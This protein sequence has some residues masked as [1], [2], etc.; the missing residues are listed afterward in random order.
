[1]MGDIAP[2]SNG[3]FKALQ[4]NS[5]TGNPVAS[6]N[7]IN[8]IVA[9]PGA[10]SSGPSAV[11][12]GPQAKVY[13]AYAGDFYS[14]VVIGKNA[15]S[16]G[17]GSVVI[18]SGASLT[19]ASTQG[20]IIGPVCTSAASNPIAIGFNV[21]VSG[22]FAVAISNQSVTSTTNSIAIGGY[23]NNISGTAAICLGAGGTA[24]NNSVFLNSTTWGN[25]V[26]EYDG[27]IAFTTGH[28][29]SGGG[30]GLGGYLIAT[31]FVNL[32]TETTN[33]TVTELGIATNGTS[34][35]TGRIVL[36]AD[37][38][39]SFNID[40]VARDTA[41]DTSSSVWSIQFAIRRGTTAATTT[42]IGSPVYTII[43][44]D[45]GAASWA[46]SVT[47]D[48]TNGRPNISVT[49]VAATTIRWMASCKV[50]RVS[51]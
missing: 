39:Y 11:V 31:S 28:W 5:N 25:P 12:I 30:A 20:V 47:A 37:S 16:N 18:G 2:R 34:A 9:G 38:T 41:T 36:L 6:G 50:T 7:G 21:N 1:M 24:K 43:G 8:S 32:I 44:Q 23:Q 22:N 29:A 17:G 46:V 10:F 40:L 26:G 51:G 49:G 15:S 19:N 33:A 14:N 35:P 42:L 4:E 45:A 27:Q 13:G 3:G 48:T